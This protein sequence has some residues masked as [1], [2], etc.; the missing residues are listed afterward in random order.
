MMHTREFLRWLL[1]PTARSTNFNRTLCLATMR[2]RQRSF[3]SERSV[4]R[5]VGSCGCTVDIRPPASIPML[6]S[7]AC[8]CTP[9]AAM[10]NTAESRLCRERSKPQYLTRSIRHRLQRCQATTH[11][12]MSHCAPLQGLCRFERRIRI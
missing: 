5:S 9:P 1:P 3:R 12:N 7:P 2:H 10:A 8:S 11:S 4:E 6:P